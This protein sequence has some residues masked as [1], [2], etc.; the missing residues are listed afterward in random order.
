MVLPLDAFDVGSIVILI[1]H[2]HDVTIAQLRNIL[3]HKVWHL[4][5]IYFLDPREEYIHL[6]RWRKLMLRSVQ[7]KIDPILIVVS[8]MRTH[9]L[10]NVL[11]DITKPFRS[12]SNHRF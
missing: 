2:H 7:Q 11:D 4:P 12:G 9:I 1:G 10:I 8:T 6:S 5:S 3:L